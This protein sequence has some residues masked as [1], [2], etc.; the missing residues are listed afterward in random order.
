MS[1]VNTFRLLL[2][3]AVAL[4]PCSHAE[5][6][7]TITVD[8]S[9][10]QKPDIPQT[11]FGTF[12]EPIGHSTYGGLWAQILENPSFEEN[13]WSAGAVDQ[14]LKTDHDL[15]QASRLGLPL[16]WEPL[17]P[18][19]GNRY[20]PRWTDAANSFRSLL[21]M[22]LPN[23]E[24]GIRQK[25]YLPAYR[26]MRYTGAIY[27]KNINGAATVEVSLRRRSP[28]LVLARASL[29]SSGDVWNRYAFA[30][31]L[32]PGSVKAV[33]PV[34][35]V[36]SLPGNDRVLVDEASLDPADAVD[37]MDP[38]MIAMSR[39]LHTPLVRFGGNF[40]SAYHWRDGIG[41]LDKRISMLNIAWGI[42]EYNQ[43]GTDEFLDFCRRVGAEPQIAVNMG[44]G[45]PAE[46]AEWVRYVN[47]KWN[48]GKGGLLWELGNELWGNWQ[49]G[50]PTIEEI[51]A[52]TKAFSEAI[53]KVDP[54]A[55][56][57]ATGADP[58]HYEKWNAAQLSGAP[59]A[60]DYLSTH[61]VVGSADIVKPN[62]SEAFDDEAEFALPIGV[63]RALHHMAEQI[64][65]YPWARDRV[66]TAFTEWLFAA[67]AQRNLVRFDNMGGAICAGGFL[68][69]LM[70]VHNLVP[71]ADMTGLIEFGGI[72]K[73]KGRVYGVPAYYVFRMYSSTE[74]RRLVDARTESPEY[75]VREG[76][77]R[78]PNIDR[79][80]Y[81]DVTAALDNSGRRLFLYCVNRSLTE[82]VAA[83][84]S[85]AGFR[86]AGD[87]RFS[88]IHSQSIL[89]GNSAE[90]P[91]AVTPATSTEPAGTQMRHTF[92]PAS[93]TVIAL[94]A[95]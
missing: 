87:A 4:A 16:P 26:V 48:G 77:R 42:P 47:A 49:V 33:E 19:Q 83:N 55:R 58:D 62:A 91:T 68:N 95:Q 20:E 11:I 23:A 5:L 93:V 44:T 71:I 80:P 46:A 57:I 34:D 78:F 60:F 15:L 39:E 65:S 1:G 52:R 9:K 59:R 29:R 31:D 2:A 67:P 32:P 79:V 56:L 82:P 89:D 81:L 88:A 90:N 14:M 6:S 64:A 73:K 74:P 86:A 66:K 70:R 94:S 3:L 10:S 53:R 76:N 18:A 84:I 40:T 63:E 13:L 22:G 12:L 7:A 21:I 43:F 85:I 37:G 92:P 35:F 28:S 27:V 54:R 61:F 51:A 45:T 17:N 75:D 25:V 41:P 8:A 24:V 50:Y 30:L 72:W 38:E 36:I 69:M